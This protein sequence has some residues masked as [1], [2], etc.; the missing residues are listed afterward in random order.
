MSKK[1]Q[2]ENPQ[3]QK[4]KKADK[5]SNKHA[6]LDSLSQ[7]IEE[8]QE[9]LKR[10]RADSENIRRRHESQLSELKT[11]VTA[12]VIRSLLPVIDNIERAKQHVPEDLA[13]N[14]YVKGVEGV[15]KQFATTLEKLGVERIATQGEEFDPEL[16]EAVSMDDSDGG[17]KEIITNELQTGYKLGGHII[18]HAMV[19]V[20]TNKK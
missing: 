9:S 1:D 10:E 18:R 5:K 6:D 19:N 12:D 14:Q 4:Q 8:L 11:Y 17:S 20:K 15:I 2:Q 13:D 3:A 7:Q 16:H